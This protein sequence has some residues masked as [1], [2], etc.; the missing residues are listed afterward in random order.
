MTLWKGDAM[1]EP[2]SIDFVEK[3]THGMELFLK[4]PDFSVGTT[5]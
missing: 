2:N 3:F 4:A 1:N 5:P